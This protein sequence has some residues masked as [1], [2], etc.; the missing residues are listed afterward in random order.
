MQK[1]HE[2]TE[3]TETRTPKTVD[4]SA[5]T[6][7]ASNVKLLE[8][9]V[10]VGPSDLAEGLTSLD[11]EKAALSDLEGKTITVI[12]YQERTG[13]LK[14]KETEYLLILAVP[15][16]SNQ[17]VIISTGASV[18]LKQLRKAAET[19]ALPLKGTVK[20]RKGDDFNYYVLE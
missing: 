9:W 15:E 16:T 17:P 13:T 8:K 7:N 6:K 18:V 1:K 2:S 12:G 4:A 5:Y 10:G 20:E 19:G 11:L 3:S 14:G